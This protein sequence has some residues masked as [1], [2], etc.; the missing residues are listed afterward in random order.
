MVQYENTDSIIYSQLSGMCSCTAL[1]HSRNIFLSNVFGILLS[2]NLHQ[3]S[4]FHHSSWVKLL[5][6]YTLKSKVAVSKLWS[7][8]I[9]LSMPIAAGVAVKSYLGKFTSR[10]DFISNCP[11]FAVTLC[12]SRQKIFHAVQD[13]MIQRRSFLVLA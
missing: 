13:C 5:Y 4:N 9:D 12:H 10:A 7:L 1:S 2:I 3:Q 8:H 11:K 6:K